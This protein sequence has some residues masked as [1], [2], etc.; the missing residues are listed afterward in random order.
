MA[1]GEEVSVAYVG[2]CPNIYLLC[3]YGFVLPQNPYDLVL[4]WPEQYSVL[5]RIPWDALLPALAD[6]LEQQ[7]LQQAESSWS[8]QGGVSDENRT[9]SSSSCSDGGGSSRGRR[10]SNGKASSSISNS[11]LQPSHSMAVAG[12]CIAA[13]ASL[14]VVDLPTSLMQNHQNQDPWSNASL[15][16][17]LLTKLQE[18]QRGE[19]AEKHQQQQQSRGGDWQDDRSELTSYNMD[20]IHIVEQIMSD[21]QAH[22]EQH[23]QQQREQQEQQQEQRLTA[24]AL[25][26]ESRVMLL[27]C[28][29]TA[30]QDQ[31][32]LQI[33]GDVEAL[34]QQYSSTTTCGCTS[35]TA[36]NAAAASPGT[37]NGAGRTVAGSTAE[38]E[39]NAVK[40]NGAVDVTE[41]KLGDVLA[42]QQLVLQKLLLLSALQ[43]PL[44]TQ[45]GTAAFAT[46]C[47]LLASSQVR[48]VGAGAGVTAGSSS[49]S[50]TEGS[51][52]GRVAG[53]GGEERM[54]AGVDLV[55]AAVA[56][57]LLQQRLRDEVVMLSLKRDAALRQLEEQ[58]QQHVG[59]GEVTSAAATAAVA[60]VPLGLLMSGEGDMSMAR[61]VAAVSARLEQ[62]LVLE[63][64]VQL[65]YALADRLGGCRVV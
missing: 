23:H 21:L 1:Q 43:Q 62:K 35:S 29:S 3:N 22:Q 41:V 36:T 57:G 52:G 8:S 40:G 54:S 2:D 9:S 26:A 42:L 18:Q 27:Q 56:D 28:P 55:C 25:A 30:Q 17:L 47:T 39:G 38:L 46:A 63:A 20:H 19:G 59:V 50:S 15:P 61:L 53:V 24:L 31:Q 44:V 5:P 10:Y 16:G 48:D 11:T 58:R 34:Q 65:C 14:P 60:G 45:V 37:S 7:E 33:L 32:L 4:A 51:G 64:G 12:R 6:V 13:A 49:S